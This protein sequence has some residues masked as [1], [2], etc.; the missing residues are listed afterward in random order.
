VETRPLHAVAIPL[1]AIAVV[2]GTD[3]RRAAATLSAATIIA[4]LAI[5]PAGAPL[6]A[7]PILA[8]LAVLARVLRAKIPSASPGL[9]ITLPLRI[10]RLVQSFIHS[11]TCELLIYLPDFQTW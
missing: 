10:L 3:K 6:V 7:G 1:I 11:Y 2:H 4:V 8:V 5:L 9:A